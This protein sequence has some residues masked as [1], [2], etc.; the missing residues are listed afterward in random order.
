MARK[1]H[2]VTAVF[3]SG[4]E[5]MKRLMIASLVLATLV[6]SGTAQAGIF[7][8]RWS[9]STY[10]QPTYAQPGYVQQPAYA[11]PMYSYQ[12]NGGYRSYSYQP[13][14]DQSNSYQPGYVPAGH[15]MSLQQWDEASWQ[16]AAHKGY[17][18]HPRGW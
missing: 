17:G 12:P 10:Y 2:P 15:P 11:Q 1:S 7:G 16:G 6:A 9:Q 14:A 13:G 18:V 5:N 3:Q 8:R 4:E